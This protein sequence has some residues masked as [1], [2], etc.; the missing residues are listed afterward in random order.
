[1]YNLKKLT[2]DLDV[3]YTADYF[4]PFTFQAIK[5]GIPTIVMEWENIP[6]NDEEPPFGKIKEFAR[7]HAAH[8]V[9]VTE[10]AKEAL[11]IEGV[12][13]EKISVLP[14][15]IDCEKFK[16]R[17][18]NEQLFKKHG[19]T[20]DSTKILFVGRL[21]LEKGI[22]DLLRAF[23]ALRNVRNIELLIVGSGAPETK[24]QIRQLVQKLKIEDRVKFLGS[25]EYSDMPAIHNLADIF[26]LPSI[27]VKTWAEQFG[28][29]MVE[30]MACGKPVIST[31]SG[32]IPE[33]VKD[34]QTGILVQ[35]KDV[36]GLVSALEKLIMDKQEREN[37]GENARNW[38]LYAF[39]ANKIAEQLSG[40]YRRFI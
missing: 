13:R 21:V 5:T 1:V 27:P 20:K 35:P 26:C 31:Y 39:E 14:V 28:Y 30:A 36:E 17:E 8:F 4:Y 34:Q 23:S 7:E 22:F 19:F 2:S 25:I 6:H 9:A 40:I 37:M 16:P 33:I 3:I 32:S 38:V 24:S 10:K 11:I 18:R 12:N 15:G 29:S